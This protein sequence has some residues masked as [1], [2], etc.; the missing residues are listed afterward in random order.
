MANTGTVQQGLISPTGSDNSEGAPTLTPGQIL[1][2]QHL[3]LLIHLLPSISSPSEFEAWLQRSP[4]LSAWAEFNAALP[5]LRADPD[6]TIV[7]RMVRAAIDEET[8]PHT[9]FRL[10][11][12]D[13]RDWSP[14]NHHI[15]FIVAVI[16]DSLMERHLD[17]LEWKNHPARTVRAVYE[18]LVYMKAVQGVGNVENFE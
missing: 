12:P 15:R 3:R 18:V 11:H 5:S 4:V 17:R 9:R 6:L 1:S 2:A 7:T 8:L 13:K 16:N 10:L 14:T